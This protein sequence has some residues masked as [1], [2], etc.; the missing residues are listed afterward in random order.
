MR[1]LAGADEG[2]EFVLPREA[3]ASLPGGPSDAAAV[4][5]AAGSPPRAKAGA[6]AAGGMVLPMKVAQ[7]STPGGEPTAVIH[8]EGGG[9]SLLPWGELKRRAVELEALAGD[10]GGG[11]AATKSSPSGGGCGRPR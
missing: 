1:V 7:G 11:D 10:G 4:G 2:R 8:W 3:L 9:E 5:A 6:K